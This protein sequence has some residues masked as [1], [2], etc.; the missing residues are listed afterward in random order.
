MFTLIIK[1]K[2]LCNNAVSR[3]HYVTLSNEE[4]I[5]TLN[6]RGRDLA[7]PVT[8]IIKAVALGGLMK[9]SGLLAKSGCRN[10]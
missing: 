1:I 2:D 9:L 3:C 6:E 8:G 5:I 10:P 7:D 4:Q